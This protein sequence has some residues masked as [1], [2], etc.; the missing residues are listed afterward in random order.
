MAAVVSVEGEDRANWQPVESWAGL[1]FG[2]AKATEG[3]TFKDATFAANWANMGREPMARGAY[4]FFHPALDPIAQ[5]EFFWNTVKAQGVRPGDMLVADVEIL[6]GGKL[7]QTIK[8]IFGRRLPRQNLP[9]AAVALAAVNPAAKAFLDEVARLAGPEHPV[10]VYTDLSVGATLSSCTGYP[11]W[12]AW[13]SRFAPLSVSP[14][15]TWTFWQWGTR[16]GMDADAF[17]G[18][19][20]AFQAW[21]SRYVKPAA[22]VIEL[23]ARPHTAN[24]T[25]SLDDLAASLKTGLGGMLQLTL[26][27][28]A[29]LKFDP[30]LRDYLN[31]GD[32]TAPVPAGVIVYYWKQVRV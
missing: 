24:G 27:H 17:N 29:S 19:M 1:S 8:R 7:M 6:S 16:N 10:L 5:A 12:I 20:A 21:L 14:W 31:A 18:D 9:M 32:L 25:E 28:S 11:L 4:H 3:L 13:P 30:R 23:L 2:F 15:R 26:R 22:P